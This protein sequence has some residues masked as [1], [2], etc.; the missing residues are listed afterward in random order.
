MKNS[1]SNHVPDQ[2]E[3]AAMGKIFSYAGVRQIPVDTRIL[4]IT[5]SDT[6]SPLLKTVATGTLSTDAYHSKIEYWHDNNLDVVDRYLNL[7]IVELSPSQITIERFLTGFKPR[8][9]INQ[10]TDYPWVTAPVEIKFPQKNLFWAYDPD[11][12]GETLIAVLLEQDNKVLKRVTWFKQVEKSASVFNLRTVDDLITG[13]ID[14]RFTRADTVYDNGV[15]D[16]SGI[17]KNPWYHAPMD[18]LT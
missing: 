17:D 14:L 5:L 1:P 13:R 4:G 8:F 3:Q 10:I 2:G 11:N 16:L 6:I 12:D 15:V 7:S 18:R 9:N